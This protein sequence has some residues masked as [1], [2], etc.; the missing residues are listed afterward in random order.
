MGR[1]F[2]T[3]GVRGVANVELTNELA[4]KLGRFG[5]HVLTENKD[6]AKIL[7][8]KDTRVSGDMLE[9]AMI[10][11]ILSAGCDVIK[12]GVLPTPAVAYLVRHLDV[13]AG[14]MISAS[15]NPVEYNG[16]KFFDNNG[17]KLPDA[18]EE[19]IEDYILND[20]DL[21]HNP[22]GTELGRKTEVFRAMD[23]YADYVKSTIDVNFEGIKIAVD[24]ANGAAYEVARKTLKDLGAEVTCIH[25]EPDGFNINA[26]CGSTHPEMVAAEVILQ[27][28]DIGL[29]FD[30]DADR[31][32][33]VDETGK[34]V[35]GDKIMAIC[36]THM[37]TKGK[38]NNDTIVATVMSN[39]GLDIAMQ[40]EAVKLEKTRVGDR[41]VL[42]AMKAGKH[43]LGGEQ[44][45][46]IIF[47][48]HNTTGDGL[49]TAVQLI[50]VM[51]ETGKK[52]SELASIM[53]TYP[54]V[55]KNAKVT[56]SKKHDYTSDDVIIKRIAEVEKHFSGQGRVL[57]RPSGTEPLV[58]VMIEG[59][60]Q[61]E[62]NQFA[63]ELVGLIEERLGR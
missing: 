39:L 41:Y 45:G 49:L 48:D 7:I 62:L 50:N 18:V 36:G 61:S 59:K 9:S 25:S 30:G 29:A 47:L 8:A 56:N 19:K 5:A 57:I 54:Q 55:L 40:G 24:A 38:L 11:G 37:K 32:I 60:D 43:S 4:Y 53:D 27:K 58:R 34:I 14:V 44:S 22:S 28:A 42:E 16:I 21:E 46:H 33:A 13:D 17:F 26:G 2:G 52:L 1:L 3:D 35:D 12:I 15:H 10:S 31:L 23:L 6:K 63:E 51:K 20:K